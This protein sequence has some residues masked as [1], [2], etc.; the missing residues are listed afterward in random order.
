MPGDEAHRKR[1]ETTHRENAR[2]W[3]T[4][5]RMK[6]LDGENAWNCSVNGVRCF[7]MLFGDKMAASGQCG[8]G[9]TGRRVSL[10][11]LWPKGCAGSNPVP[12]TIFCS[13]FSCRGYRFAP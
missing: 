12:R 13:A 8:D 6:T 10:R 5:K 7:L 4:R 11:R 1:V 9:G 3:R 2:R